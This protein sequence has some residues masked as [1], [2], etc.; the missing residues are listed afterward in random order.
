[1]LTLQIKKRDN[2]TDLD[3]LRKEDNTLAVFYGKGVETT[4]IYMSYVEFKKVWKKAGSSAIITLSGVGE[5]KEVLIHDLDINPI[6]NQVRHVDFYVIERGKAM[7][8]GVPLEFIGESS[9][10]KTLGG[11]LIKVL[12][13]LEI[14]VM[15][16]DLPQHIEV[17]ISSLAELD[18]HITIADLKLP[19]GVKALGDPEEVVVSVSQAK[20]EEEVE[21][22]DVADVQIEKKGKKE[23]GD[24]EK[25]GEKK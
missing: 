18:S 2:K 12:H 1:M 22:A 10:V 9:A 21:V 19:K 24:G 16:K 15:P 25:E 5:D 11:I 8:V 14:E 4:S 17:D 3:K 23:E 6:T 13:E 20:E 7:E